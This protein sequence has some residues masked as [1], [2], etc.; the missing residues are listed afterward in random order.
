RYRFKGGEQ[1]SIAVDFANDGL[2]IPRL[3]GKASGTVRRVDEQTLSAEMVLSGITLYFFIRCEGGK[4]AELFMGEKLYD[5]DSLTLAEPEDIRFGGIFR[6]EGDCELRVSISA[7]SMAHAEE[8]LA[9]ESRSFSEIRAD[10]DRIWEQMLSRI[11]IETD[12]QRELEIFYSNFDHTLIK[13]VDLSGEA[14][15]FREKAQPFV[16]DVATM[17]DIYKT[18]LPLLFM[19]YPE[20]SEKLLHTFLQFGKEYGYYPHCMLVSGNMG[21]ESKQ[22]RMLAEFSICDAYY[23]G[24]KA[25]YPALLA[26]SEKD[27]ERYPDFFSEGGCEMSSHT[28]DMAEAFSSLSKLAAVLGDTTRAGKFAEY[29]TYAAKAFDDD[30]MMRADSWYYEGNRY[31]YSFRPAHDRAAR[32]RAAGSLANLQKEAERF[33]GFTEPEN[34]DS[35][36]EGFNNETDMEAPAFLHEV[37]L[38]DRMCEVIRSGLDCMF[39]TGIGGIPGNADS[40]GLTACYLWNVLGLFPLTGHDRVI[41]GTPRYAKAVMHLPGGKDLTIERTGGDSI[42]PASVSID[43]DDLPDFEI[44]ASRLQKGGTLRFIM[45]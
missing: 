33:F 24:V 29:G 18:Q 19:L 28:L 22:A 1:H 39:T 21:I 4:T 23:R 44:S 42:Y 45:R 26:L 31:N 2:Y 13:P 34:F 10:A 43:G 9:D 30:G 6:T 25:D 40:G 36:F 3:R 17:W 16:T 5:D 15:L 11:E 20:I 38:R 27:A 32:I 35:R 8:L 12:D 14:F 41:L 7:V 37:G